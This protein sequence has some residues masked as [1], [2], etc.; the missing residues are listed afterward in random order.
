MSKPKGECPSPL[1]SI[2]PK[3]FPDGP[4]TTFPVLGHPSL[5]ES[6][7]S[8]SNQSSSWGQAGSSKGGRGGALARKISFVSLVA[9]GTKVFLLSRSHTAS[10]TRQ[11]GSQQSWIPVKQNK[12][13]SP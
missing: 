11:A 7:L 10:E 3:S 9:Y 4:F 13:G 5:E 2:A 12:V 8:L 6:Y 1:F